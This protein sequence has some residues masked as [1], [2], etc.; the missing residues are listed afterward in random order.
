VTTAAQDALDALMHKYAPY[1]LT[2]TLTDTMTNPLPDSNATQ[3]TTLPD[4]P[5]TTALV[6]KD[7]WKTMEGKEVWKKRRNEN[8]NNEPVV[9]TMRIYTTWQR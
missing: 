3:D 5:A 4:A 7:G 9:T 2:I 6:A 8:A 1:P